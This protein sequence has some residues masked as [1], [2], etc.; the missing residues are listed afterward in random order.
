MCK[1]QFRQLGRVLCGQ[2]NRW[3]VFLSLLSSFA[4]FVWWSVFPLVDKMREKAGHTLWSLISQME[5]FAWQLYHLEAR[6][7]LADKDLNASS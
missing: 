7:A 3:P 4:C 2:H 1:D 6:L 5:P